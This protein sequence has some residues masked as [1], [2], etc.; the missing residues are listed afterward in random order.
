MGLPLKAALEKANGFDTLLGL[1][2][3]LKLPDG[4]IA[5]RLD[6]TVSDWI[7][8]KNY[9]R[10]RKDWLRALRWLLVEKWQHDEDV[11]TNKIG[12]SEGETIFYDDTPE[13]GMIMLAH[14]PEGFVL[15]YDGEIVWRSWLPASKDEPIPTGPTPNARAFMAANDLWPVIS[16]DV[17]NDKK[18]GARIGRYILED[19][20]RFDLTTADARTL[21]EGYPIWKLPELKPAEPT[22]QDLVNAMHRHMEAIRELRA[23]LYARDI[24]IEFSAQT[25]A[26]NNPWLYARYTKQMAPKDQ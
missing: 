18:T 9:D 2:A 23:Q 5:T 11:A 13:G 6:C 1:Q 12:L 17:S 10:N 14:W 25:E 8:A 16:G 26:A 7:N 21:P 4:A 20:K 24:K 15:R 22:D 3:E 19:G